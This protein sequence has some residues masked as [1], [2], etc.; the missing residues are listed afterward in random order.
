MRHMEREVASF[1]PALIKAIDHPPLADIVTR[2]RE[3]AQRLLAILTRISGVPPNDT[4]NKDMQQL[5][6]NS[7]QMLRTERKSAARDAKIIAVAEKIISLEIE[8]CSCLI[9]MAAKLGYEEEAE[10]MHKNLRKKDALEKKLSAYRRKYY[11]TPHALRE[12]D[13]AGIRRATLKKL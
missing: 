3:T 12:G 8:G 2:Q 6:R 5:L 1:L 13:A 9:S 7:T 11:G 10:S 4:V